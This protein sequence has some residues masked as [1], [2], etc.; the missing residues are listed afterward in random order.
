MKEYIY[1]ACG[2]GRLRLRFDDKGNEY[3][4]IKGHGSSKGRRY[5]DD[6]GYVHIFNPKH[7][8]WAE[9]MARFLRFL[10]TIYPFRR[11]CPECGESFPHVHCDGVHMD[12]PLHL[13]WDGK[14]AKELPCAEAGE[15]AFRH[16]C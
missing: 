4:F 7:P 13:A 6:Q 14:E 10:K 2:C 8:N 9:M 1:C 12:N 16:D 15:W 3:K 11:H 5:I